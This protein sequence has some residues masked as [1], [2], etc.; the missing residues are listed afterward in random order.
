M[1]VV[2]AWDAHVLQTKMGD[3]HW[4]ARKG[5]I[6]RASGRRKGPLANEMGLVAGDRFV[7][8]GGCVMLASLGGFW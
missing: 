6:S 3:S 1:Y 5:M 4:L 7:G 8:C 2:A